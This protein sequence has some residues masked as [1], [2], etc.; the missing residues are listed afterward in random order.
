[1]LKEQEQKPFWDKKKIL[2]LLILL[3]MAVAVVIRYDQKYNKSNPISK[4]DNP[5]FVIA[6]DFD[7]S[8]NGNYIAYITA[9]LDSV[10]NETI[11]RNPISYD[12]PGTNPLEVEAGVNITLS[13]EC[14]LNATFTGISSL[15]EGLNIIRH[16]VVVT[17]INGT[18]VFSQQNFTYI[19]GLDAFAPMYIYKHQVILDFVPERGDYYTVIVTYEVFY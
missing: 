17:C 9:Y 4:D 7:T 18:T 6:Y 1:M 11:Y 14:W 5:K 10:P 15:A 8:K 3:V 2:A 16:S 19:S 13:M 12:S